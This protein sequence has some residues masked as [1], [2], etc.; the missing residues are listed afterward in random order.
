MAAGEGWMPTTTTTERR[1]DKRATAGQRRPAA[2]PRRKTGR[3][4]TMKSAKI[5]FNQNKSVLDCFV[6]DLSDTGARLSLGDLAAVPRIFT[7]E[8]HDGTLL[9]CERVRAMGLEIG[10]RFLK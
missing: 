10:V 8:L 2:S 1:S 5:L 4:N 6:R 7:L 9:R 3:N